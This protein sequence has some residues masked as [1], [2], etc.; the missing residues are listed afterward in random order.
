MMYTVTFRIAIRRLLLVAILFFQ[1]MSALSQYS[2]LVDLLVQQGNIVPVL[3]VGAGPAGLEAAFHTV[4]AALPT[5]VVKGLVGSQLRRSYQVD[6]ILGTDPASGAAIVDVLEKQALGAGVK[7]LE[8]WVERIEPATGMSSEHCLFRV[9]LGSGKVIHALTVIIATGSKAKQLEVPGENR[10]EQQG[11]FYCAVCD[12]RAARNK[13]V[14]VV[15]GGDS[16]IDAVMHLAPH[17]RSLTLLIRGTAFRAKWGLQERLRSY[18]HVTVRYQTQIAEIQGDD[19]QM[20]NLVLKDTRTGELSNLAAEVLFVAIG[21]KPLTDWCSSVVPCDTEGYI[22]VEGRS[23]RT[24]VPGIFAGG[25]V[26]DPVYKQAKTA[27]GDGLRAGFDAKLFLQHRGFTPEVAE[28]LRDRGAYFTD[29][30]SDE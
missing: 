24:L 26:V 12:A 5:V 23:G 4:Q 29:F 8:D 3:V 10:Y 19:E 27:A 17:A 21:H 14:V 22:I 20:K 11:V 9:F 18:K 6:N 15:G 30:A 16:A 7:F 28:L 13:D 2:H 25:D 1:S